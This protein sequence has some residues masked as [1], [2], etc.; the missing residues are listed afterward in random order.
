MAHSAHEQMPGRLNLHRLRGKKMST[1]CIVMTSTTTI[2]FARSDDVLQ[3]V[4][5]PLFRQSAF[6][7][8]TESSEQLPSEIIKQHITLLVHYYTVLIRTEMLSGLLQPHFQGKSTKWGLC[9]PVVLVF[10]ILLSVRNAANTSRYQSHQISLE[11]KYNYS[12]NGINNSD[13][14]I[15]TA[16][17][18]EKTSVSMMFHVLHY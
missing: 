3:L 13:P 1:I 18:D 15:I 5:K 4:S 6:L 8:A 7:H 12:S 16:N 9:A 14:T 17:H 2:W 11:N 10:L